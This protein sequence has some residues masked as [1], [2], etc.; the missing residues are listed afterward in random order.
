MKTNDQKES[1]GKLK[2]EK[3][4][5]KKSSLGSKDE[6]SVDRRMKEKC[7]ICHIECKK[8]YLK[9][10]IE[11]VHEKIVN[12]ICDVC[13]RGYYYKFKLVPH[14]KVRIKF[15]IVIENTKNYDFRITSISEIKNVKFVV[16]VM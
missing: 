8:I 11:S 5:T 9:A 1:S 3:T 16:K 6:K 10:H 7:N 15:Q 4:K 14:L 12:Y 2:K 13:G